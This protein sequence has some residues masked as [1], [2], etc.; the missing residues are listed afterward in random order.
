MEYNLYVF[1][2]NWIVSCRAWQQLKG[3]DLLRERLVPRPLVIATIAFVRKWD[4]LDWFGF[5]IHHYTST[6]HGKSYALKTAIL[7]YTCIWQVLKASRS[8]SKGDSKRQGSHGCWT[9]GH[10]QVCCLSSCA[11]LWRNQRFENL[12]YLYNS[13]HILTSCQQQQISVPITGQISLCLSAQAVAAE[14]QFRPSLLFT[15]GKPRGIRCARKLRVH[16]KEAL[17]ADKE[18][19]DA[20]GTFWHQISWHLASK[21]KLPGFCLF[22]QHFIW[23]VFLWRTTRRQTW[24][25]STSAILSEANLLQQRVLFEWEES[26]AL[27][28]SLI[29]WFEK[30]SS[31]LPA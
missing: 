31:W 18:L 27:L 12:T 13:I 14:A 3:S 5:H 10:T 16:R 8:R 20:S 2:H 28:S 30:F 25:P 4:V 21:E 23:D 17:W 15:M 19:L 22:L 24:V 1:V 9:I 6:Y 26:Y 11:S 7:C 29:C